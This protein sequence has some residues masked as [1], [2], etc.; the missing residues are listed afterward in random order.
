MSNPKALNAEWSEWGVKITE[1][2]KLEATSRPV[3]KSLVAEITQDFDSV[4]SE[5][6]IAHFVL[7][8]L[9]YY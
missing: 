4:F 6:G 9:S 3:I 5:R 7:I 8:S 1:F 2:A